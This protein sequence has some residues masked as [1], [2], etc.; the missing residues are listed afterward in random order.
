MSCD[1]CV[2]FWN[3]LCNLEDTALSFFFV[4]ALTADVKSRN[5]QI[6]LTFESLYCLFQ[7][8]DWV[9]EIEVLE[10]LW[11]TCL[12]LLDMRS[13]SADDRDANAIDDV[14]LIWE[15]EVLFAV[16]LIEIIIP[17]PEIVFGVTIED[18]ESYLLVKLI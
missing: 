6:I 2:E 4:L 16:S 13:N 10:M 18:I 1:N 12:P 15:N 11:R 14:N 7:R 9:C 8:I 17:E 3:S 5:E